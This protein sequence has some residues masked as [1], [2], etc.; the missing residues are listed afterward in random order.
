MDK[1]WQIHTLAMGVANVLCMRSMQE[2]FQAK[3]VARLWLH[4]LHYFLWVLWSLAICHLY[5][6]RKIDGMSNNVTECGNGRYYVDARGVKQC[7]H[8]HCSAGCD[9]PSPERCF[10]SLCDGGGGGDQ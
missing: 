10:V 2:S 3:K 5:S 7:C 6:V 1:C 4:L 8:P 9:G